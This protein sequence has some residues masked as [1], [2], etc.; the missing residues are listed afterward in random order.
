MG[1]L[2]KWCVYLHIFVCPVLSRDGKVVKHNGFFV[3]VPLCCRGRIGLCESYIVNVDCSVC[4][5]NWRNEVAN[6]DAVF[7]SETLWRSLCNWT[8]TLCFNDCCMFCLFVCVCV[9]VTYSKLSDCS[10]FLR[11]TC[12]EYCAGTG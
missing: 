6:S 4:V 11:F 2:N 12:C 8:G 3:I 9:S 10:P 5:F 1:R 7:G